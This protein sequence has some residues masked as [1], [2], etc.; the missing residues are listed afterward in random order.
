MALSRFVNNNISG[1]NDY[2]MNVVKILNQ[3]NVN[4][5]KK[6]GITNEIEKKNQ[7]NKDL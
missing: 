4:K 5:N 1:N 3:N 6:N 2:Y 7:K